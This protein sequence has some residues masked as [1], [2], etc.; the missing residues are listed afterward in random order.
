MSENTQGT[1]AKKPATVYHAVT[2]TDGRVVEFPGNRQ[3]QKEII[4]TADS[5]SVRFD[6]RNGDTRTYTCPATLLLQA[7][8][9]GLSQK[10]GDAAASEKDVDDALLAIEKVGDRIA[11]GEWNAVA[12]QAGDSFSGASLV[13]KALTLE[14]GKSV[15][16]IK[17]FLEKKLEAGKE[18]GLTR[19][20]LYAAFRNPATKVG[21][22]IAQLQAEKDAKASGVS[23][24]DLLSELAQ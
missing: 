20:K 23:G 5:V 21:Q 11:Q 18:A 4:V 12:R 1:A 7:A 22:R 3:I 8:G 17:D 24:D 13:I 10:I 16:E 19:A 6:F 15:S 14:T 9:H 2:L